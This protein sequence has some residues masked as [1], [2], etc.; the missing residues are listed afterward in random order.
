MIMSVTLRPLSESEEGLVNSLLNLQA[1]LEQP[2]VRA[3]DRLVN[4]EEFINRLPGFD[5][6]CK[7]DQTII[8]KYA[9]TESVMI[10]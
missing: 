10:R 8:L 5:T 2:T 1:E 3:L 9:S 4:M 6:L 7:E